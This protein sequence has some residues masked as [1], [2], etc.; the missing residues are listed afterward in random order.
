VFGAVAKTD[1]DLGALIRGSLDAVGRTK[2]TA[3]TALP[4]A[5]PGC[6]AFF[7]TPASLDF[8]FWTGFTSPCGCST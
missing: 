4:T 1:T 8:R 2:D 5:V 6:G 3:L 7:S